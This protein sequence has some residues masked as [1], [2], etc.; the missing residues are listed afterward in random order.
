MA[1][2]KK[3]WK[4]SF[5]FIF[6]FRMLL[7]NWLAVTNQFLHILFCNNYK[8]PTNNRKM[9]WKSSKRELCH[10][11]F[12]HYFWIIIMKVFKEG[13]IF[14]KICLVFASFI[15]MKFCEKIRTK[16]FASF[17]ETFRLLQTLI[18]VRTSV[19]RSTLAKEIEGFSGDLSKRL[20]RSDT[21]WGQ[22][23]RL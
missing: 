3:H 2:Q 23:T 1:T 18:S 19:I 14:R 5:C 13:E 17:R 8:I 7:K 10:F 12:S 22:L 15:F 16:I 9:G 21:V 20:N 4:L 6:S 11:L